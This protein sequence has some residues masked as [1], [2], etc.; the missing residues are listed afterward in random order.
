M[1]A[2]E[3]PTLSAEQLAG[4][5]EYTAT[6]VTTPPQTLTD[7]FLGTE[8]GQTVQSKA[9]EAAGKLTKANV[10]S[11]LAKTYGPQGEAV[12]DGSYTS[13]DIPEM[14]QFGMA[15][16][17]ADPT[18]RRISRTQISGYGTTSFDNLL[19]TPQSSWGKTFA[20]LRGMA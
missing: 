20:E 4:G 19:Y 14:E 9:T 10:M 6:G 18:Q 7:K 11:A 3:V 12:G 1:S 15:A 2:P 5:Y 16:T 17:V 8:V 13:F